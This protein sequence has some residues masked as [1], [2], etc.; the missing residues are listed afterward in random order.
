LHADACYGA[1]RTRTRAVAKHDPVEAELGGRVDYVSRKGVL[2]HHRRPELCV[3]VFV[4]ARVW[5]V[6]AWVRGNVG[7]CSC[8]CMRACA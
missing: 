6:C 5:H 7:V 1:R 2:A 4:R 8:A 3:C